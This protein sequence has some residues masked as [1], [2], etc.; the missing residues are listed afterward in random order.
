M[1]TAARRVPKGQLMLAV[2]YTLV[3]AAEGTGAAGLLGEWLSMIDMLGPVAYASMHMDVKTREW[4]RVQGRIGGRKRVAALSEAERSALAQNAAR[5]RWGWREGWRY[6]LE[7]KIDGGWVHGAIRAWQPGENPRREP[8]MVICN[9]RS[10]T[11]Q[12]VRVLARQF[13][14]QWLQGQ[15]PRRKKKGTR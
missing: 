12:H 9:F 4:F 7:T 5:A 13:F 3:T 8:G 11:V 14:R 2:S 6:K 1:E 15:I 10:L